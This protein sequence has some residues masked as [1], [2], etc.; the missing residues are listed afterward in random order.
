MK[1][2]YAKLRQLLVENAVDYI[3]DFSEYLTPY[4]DAFMTKLKGTVYAHLYSIFIHN[5]GE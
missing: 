5:N 2:R 4:V 3:E 1:A